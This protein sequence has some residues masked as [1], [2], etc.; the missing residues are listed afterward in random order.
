MQR[1][2]IVLCANSEVLL[3]MRMGMGVM[4]VM[5]RM[6]FWQPGFGL[7]G[8]DFRSLEQK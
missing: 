6:L 3:M 1:F 5:A 7:Q 4:T 8:Q 2:R